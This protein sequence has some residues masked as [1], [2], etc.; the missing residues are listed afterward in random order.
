MNLVIDCT[1][2]LLNFQIKEVGLTRP[3][4]A[5]QFDVSQV[6]ISRAINNDTSLKTLRKKIIDLV[7]SKKKNQ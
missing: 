2:N 3:E 6:A 1:P 7:N 4:L 5:D